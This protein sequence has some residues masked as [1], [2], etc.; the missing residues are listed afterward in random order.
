M[1]Q[2]AEDRYSRELIAHAESIK[3]AETLK[4]QL[5]AVRATARDQLAAA[6]TAQGKLS[7]SEASWRQQ[8]DAL[9]KEVADLNSRYQDSFV[10]PSIR[11]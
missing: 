3:T 9:D 2:A 8:K 6:E 11:I 7:S 4:Q 1:S 5:E 10:L